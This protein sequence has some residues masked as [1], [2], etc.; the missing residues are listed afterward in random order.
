VTAAGR[1]G[2]AGAREL[3]AALLAASDDGSG[4]GRQVVLDL[5]AVDY[6]SS[7]GLAVIENAAARLRGRNATLVVRGAEGA[8][9][10]SFDFAGLLPI[11]PV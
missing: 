1:V 3:E 9:K 5:A 8:T 7:A 4:A 6:I 2:S 10:L 11:V